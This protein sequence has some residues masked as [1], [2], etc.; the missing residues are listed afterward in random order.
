MNLH[1]H[2]RL[3]V[4]GQPGAGKTTFV[5]HIVYK[6]AAERNEKNKMLHKFL[7]VIPIILRLVKHG[8]ELPDIL[9][10]Q[11]PLNKLDVFIIQHALKQSS[12]LMLVLDGYDEIK[13]QGIIQKILRKKEYPNATVIITTRPH[14]LPLIHQLGYG[15]VQMLVEII[16]FNEK[17]IQNYIEKFMLANGQKTHGTLFRQISSDDRLLKLA[18]NPTRLEIICCVW[19]THGDL[20]QRLSELYQIFLISLLK[21]MERKFQPTLPPLEDKKLL[22]QYKPFL[23]KL[24]QMANKWDEN[25]CLQAIFQHDQLQECLGDDLEI[26]KQLGCIVKYNPSKSDALS[27]WSFT[28]LTLQYYFIA[29]FLSQGEEEDAR[30]FAE[31]CSPITQMD[32]VW[33]IMQFVC[34]ME[35]NRANTI[36]Q[37]Y[38]KMASG[39]TECLKLQKFLCQLINEYKSL[40]EINIQLPEYVVWTQEQDTTSLRILSDSD[41]LNNH[42][43]MRFFEVKRFTKA[44]K[45]FNL[46]YVPN[47]FTKL[48]HQEDFKIMT[49]S[50]KCASNLQLL[51]L[52]ISR[53]DA[54]DDVETLLANAAKGIYEIRTSGYK[55][56]QPVMQQVSNFGSLKKLHITDKGENAKQIDSCLPQ[57]TSSFSNL[58]ISVERE[59]LDSSFIQLKCQGNLAFHF[60]RT[61]KEELDIL[62]SRIKPMDTDKFSSIKCLNLSGRISRQNAITSQ[63]EAIGLLLVKMS[64]ME[65]LRMDY[66]K[67]TSDTLG[68]MTPELVRE[69]TSLSLKCLS[70]NGNNFKDGG[71]KLSEILHFTPNLTE[72]QLG[73]S[74]LDDADVYQ[75]TQV[76]SQ[77][78]NLK[79]LNLSGNAFEK[80]SSRE[81]PGLMNN[82]PQLTVLNMGWCNIDANIMDAIFSD[83]QIQHLK[84]LDLRYN[85]L[86]DGGLRSLASHMS[87][88]PSLKIL[89]LSC[90][91]CSD[92]A[93]L[94]MLCGRIPVSL[95]ELDVRSNPFNKEI[96]K[97]V[98]ITVNCM[99]ELIGLGLGLHAKETNINVLDIFSKKNKLKSI[100][101]IVTKILKM[102]IINI[103]TYLHLPVAMVN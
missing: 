46:S 27:D 76:T 95:E 22:Q 15:A 101:F 89:N 29:Y 60:R 21:H 44:M 24:S 75:M 84:Q 80:S 32:T 74:Q 5:K 68:M 36:C 33:G 12:S 56:L 66:C 79:L 69:D 20:G 19:V 25:G 70:M 58:D 48:R 51:D 86:G 72:L 49:E 67:L 87:Q 102:E 8:S 77:N 78:P 13:C 23:I 94:V 40:A 81:M 11:L 73:D 10:E 99:A 65:T 54:T 14:G 30:R 6:W 61:E 88:M 9:S 93:E 96:V 31:S 59:L 37:T 3:V 55:I 97:V 98:I 34:P 53:K 7:F 17:Q 41:N 47:I 42:K 83:T 71:D 52:A 103:E 38:V 28:H 90:C 62:K 64:H 18:T 45:E 4:I 91:G 39:K 1:G 35:A 82:K 2:K 26:A 43:N 92:A 100:L 16:G 85:H 50:I 63:G 57:N